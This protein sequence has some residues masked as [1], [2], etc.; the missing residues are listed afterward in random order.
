[1]SEHHP[2]ETMPVAFS[3][4]DS[5]DLS[6]EL[7]DVLLVGVRAPEE[8]VGPDGLLQRL[9]KRLVEHGGRAHRPSRL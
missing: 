8:I 4:P 5:P 1:M 2:E 7:I 3:G 9:T 6:D